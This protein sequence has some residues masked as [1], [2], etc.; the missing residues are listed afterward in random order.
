MK[1]LLKVVIYFSLFSVFPAYFS[2]AQIVVPTLREFRANPNRPAQPQLIQS[3]TRIDRKNKKIYIPYKLVDGGNY[4]SE[5]DVDLY[6]TQDDGQT[7]VGPLAKVK[8][9]VGENILA[10]D[11]KRIIWDFAIENPKFTGQN[12]TF[13][14]EARYRPS[15][16]NLKNEEAM[17]YSLLVPGLGNN[18]VKNTRIRFKWVFIA[19]ATYGLI[20]SSFY[21]KNLS[22]QNY[23]KY[24]AA[25]TAE[26]AQREYNL[27]NTEYVIAN[28]SAITAATLWAT[29][30]IR[31]GIRGAWNR[32]QKQKILEKNIRLNQEALIG[33]NPWNATPMLSLKIDF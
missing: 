13:K 26:E 9:H 27:A 11:D 8:G 31:V 30:I 15:V 18:K 12:V 14:L 33:V 16:F 5:F 6:Y 29:N 23:K 2:I 28:L 17:L 1:N 24:L 22:D 19:L 20:G 10:G 3:R 4:L 21:F 7:F 25:T 32:R